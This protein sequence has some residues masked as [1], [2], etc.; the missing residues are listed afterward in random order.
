MSKKADT[1]VGETIVKCRK[2]NGISQTYLAKEIGISQQGLLKI[3]KGMVSPRAITIVKIAEV[4]CV[5]P[6]QLFGVDDVTEKNSNI[7]RNIR[8]AGNLKMEKRD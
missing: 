6:N 5:T 4:L 1:K 3:E 2:L 7:L 8:E